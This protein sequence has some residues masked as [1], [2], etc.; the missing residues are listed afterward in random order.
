MNRVIIIRGRLGRSIHYLSLTELGNRPHTYDV[1]NGMYMLGNG[2][3]VSG[4]GPNVLVNGSHML[5]NGLHVLGN[6]LHMC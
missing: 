2:L 3:H 6:G 5:G 4:N 1:G